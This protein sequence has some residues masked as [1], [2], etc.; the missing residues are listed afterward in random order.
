MRHGTA[1]QHLLDQV[2]PSS[3]PVEFVAQQ[4][5]GGARGVTETAVNATAQYP[6]RSLTQGCVADKFGQL[7]LQGLQTSIH[8]TRVED[9]VWIEGFLQVFVN[10]HQRGR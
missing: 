10:V 9:A 6:V 8:T 3:G 5:I 2:D 4:L 1:L 7:G